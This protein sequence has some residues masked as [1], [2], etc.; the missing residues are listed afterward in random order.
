M[1]QD[2]V[3]E[4]QLYNS[5]KTLL[6][7]MH[8]QGYNTDTYDG[9]SIEEINIMFKESED[10]MDML[11]RKP[12]KQTLVKYHVQRTL[13]TRSL[14]EMVD[15][16]F[17]ADGVLTKNDTLY[18][19][20]ANEVNESLTN[21]V[22]QLFDTQSCHVILVPLARLLFNI[23]DHV[24]SLPHTILTPQEQ[25]DVIQKYYI[26]SMTEFPK[27][28]RF[29]PMA[30][31]IGIRPGQVCAIQRGSKTAISSTYYRVCV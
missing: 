17:G 16:L 19:V 9:F 12:D 6:K 13:R 18:V 22:R 14:D 1:S 27:L 23:F 7:W 25:E 2:S 5:R 31:A 30:C 24:L 10:V 11:F 28:S 20:V 21:H 29:D 3:L 4:Q 26:S 8:K 15:I